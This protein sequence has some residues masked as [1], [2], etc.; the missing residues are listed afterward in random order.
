MWDVGIKRKGKIVNSSSQFPTEKVVR[1]RTA[2]DQLKKR[3][4]DNNR[5]QALQFRFPAFELKKRNYT[6]SFSIS[7]QM[8]GS[9]SFAPSSAPQVSG[10]MKDRVL[11]KGQ[12]QKNCTS[13][14][15]GSSRLLSKKMPTGTAVH[16]MGEQPAN[17]ISRKSSVFTIDNL[18]APSIK[19]PASPPVT[20]NNRTSISTPPSGTPPAAFTN[21][22]MIQQQFQQYHQQNFFSVVG[23]PSH[24]HLMPL[25]LADPTSYGYAYLGT[26]FYF[27]Q[28]KSFPCYFRLWSLKIETSQSRNHICI[29]SV[30][31]T[32]IACT[33]Y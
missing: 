13:P 22:D 25:N 16:K 1:L 23:H 7:K 10:L 5:V 9:I 29:Q 15:S 20:V 8:A 26:I 14:S 33:V 2:S 19:N 6:Y 30:D 32:K 31:S 3:N 27:Y 12:Q 21:S 11:M 17:P 28:I 24:Q 4:I 18:L